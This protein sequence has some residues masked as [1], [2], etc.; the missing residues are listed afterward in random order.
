MIVDRQW[1]I[2]WF[3][4]MRLNIRIKETHSPNQNYKLETLNWFDQNFSTSLY[5]KMKILKTYDN[6]SEKSLTNS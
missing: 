1:L 6:N 3:N 4:S 5:I 2:Y